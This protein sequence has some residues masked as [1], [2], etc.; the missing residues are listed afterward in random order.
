MTGARGQGQAVGPAKAN[1]PAAADPVV[2]FSEAL[3][4]SGA[5]AQLSAATGGASSGAGEDGARAS[6]A[7]AQGAQH[8]AGGAAAAEAGLDDAAAA[9]D[10]E[11]DPLEL[12]YAFAQVTLGLTSLTY[13]VLVPVRFAMLYTVD[14][15]YVFDYA[16]DVIATA[17][18]VP[19]LWEMWLL[20][21]ENHDERY[22]K[23]LMLEAIAKGED[24]VSAARRQIQLQASARPPRS[25]WQMSRPR[26]GH[27]HTSQVMEH[28]AKSMRRTMSAGTL[29]KARGARVH[30]FAPSLAAD[31][32]AEEATDRA[33]QRMPRGAPMRQSVQAA[34]HTAAEQGTKA[35]ELLSNSAMRFGQLAL[36][37]IRLVQRPQSISLA[38]YLSD[39]TSVG[40]NFFLMLS[41]LPWD[42]VWLGVLGFENAYPTCAPRAAAPRCG[43]ARA[44]ARVP[45]RAD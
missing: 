26:H 2:K 29:A 31:D 6:G 16:L 5:S 24:G 36:V 27:A 42:L 18:L 30:A 20:A 22:R 25:S 12:W 41:C 38:D 33:P 11:H 15:T 32:V 37:L 1:E 40:F 44:R 35:K 19:T 21:L 34:K 39:F 10:H 9:E 7:R 28:A 14:A 45:S 8:V 43:A 13:M 17:A 4:A 3:P 23:A